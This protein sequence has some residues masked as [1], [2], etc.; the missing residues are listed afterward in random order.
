MIDKSAY[1]LRISQAGPVQLVVIN[2][3][4]ILEFLTSAKDIASKATSSEDMDS[5]RTEIQKAKNGLEQLIH[6][7]N[8]DQPMA[9]EFYGIYDYLYKRLSDVHYT[10]DPAKALEVVNE[11]IEITE[12]LLNGW[13]ETA[14][15][16]PDEA[17][18]AGEAPKVYSGLTYGRDGQ[19]QEYID[20][21]SDSRS[22][23]A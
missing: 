10:L 15:K 4:L 12:T 11:A 2:F 8:F 3:E 19:A 7:L 23:M 16:M 13:Q 1:M 21:G 17:P 9:Y 22:Y 5:F 6:S 18:I 14:A 20:D